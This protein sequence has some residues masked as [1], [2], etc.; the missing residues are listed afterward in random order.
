MLYFYLLISAVCFVATFLA[1]LYGGG[2]LAI[3]GWAFACIGWGGAAALLYR[4]DQ[5]HKKWQK[6][7]DERI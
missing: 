4:L 1:G 6:Q 5:T 3:F 2:P 7:I